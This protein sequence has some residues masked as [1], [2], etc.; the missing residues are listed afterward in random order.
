MV[1]NSKKCSPSPKLLRTS[2]TSTWLYFTRCC[3]PTFWPALGFLAANLL[4]RLGRYH[5]LSQFMGRFVGF[6]YSALACCR[7]GTSGSASFQRVGRASGARLEADCQ[8][9]GDWCRDSL[10][11]R[12]NG[13]QNS[14]N[15]LLNPLTKLTSL[16]RE[17]RFTRHSERPVVLD[18]CILRI[19]K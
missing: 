19:A 10:S 6:A 11:A 18:R 7:I 9:D 14:G 8:R 1:G 2:R 12:P 5:P 15:G 17:A 16:I 4:R 3:H 13:F